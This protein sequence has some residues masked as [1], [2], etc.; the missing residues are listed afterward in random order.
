MN[1]SFFLPF[2]FINSS[3][4]FFSLLLRR[5]GGCANSCGPWANL[6]RDPM[7]FRAPCFLVEFVWSLEVEGPI[8]SLSFSFPL[9]W[10]NSN[11]QSKRKNTFFENVFWYHST[12]FIPVKLWLRLTKR[13]ST[14]IHFSLTPSRARNSAEAQ[15]FA[16]ITSIPLKTHLV[17]ILSGHSQYSPFRHA[18]RWKKRHLN[19]LHKKP[20]EWWKSIQFI[21]FG[22]Q[23]QTSLKC[24]WKPAS[25][26]H[27]R[28]FHDFSVLVKQ[29]VGNIYTP[30][31]QYTPVMVWVP[32]KGDYMLPRP[33]FY[34]T[35]RHIV[36]AIWVVCLFVCFFV[37]SLYSS[38][39]RFRS[40]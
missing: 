30:V 33:P 13:K 12:G 3:F 19:V 8:I 28:I 31:R 39:V 29:V 17:I 18:E 38:F 11:C 6:K 7:G 35:I 21:G 23:L 36:E 15:L 40:T 10:T 27:Q 1:H 24:N 9:E 2:H 5:S 34:Q 32:R 37:R 16:G 22:R 14:T 20:V 4:P 25:V 26:S